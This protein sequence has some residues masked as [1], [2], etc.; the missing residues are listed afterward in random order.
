MMV[1]VGH[2]LYICSY[3][4]ALD[5]PRSLLCCAY[6]RVTH[7]PLLLEITAV[8]HLCWSSTPVF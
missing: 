4:P 5:S 2:K 8:P 6:V 1:E 3:P 7:A